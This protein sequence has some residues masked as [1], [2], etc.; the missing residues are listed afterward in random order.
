MTLGKFT[1]QTGTAAGKK[2]GIRRLT[3]RKVEEGLGPLETVEDAMRRLD[4]L[5]VWITANLLTGAQ[6]SA[7]C[8]ALEI[9][10]KGYESK[11]T[12][13]VVDEV[14]DRLERLEG[15]IK[16]QRAMGVVR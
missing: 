4:R 13:H 8:R 12:Q 5:N 16:Q 3:L 14:K 1:P 11:L 7:A 9:W 15:Q 2:S 6:G 10:L